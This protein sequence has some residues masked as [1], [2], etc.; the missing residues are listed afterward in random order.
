M[1]RRRPVRDAA[2]EVEMLA[3]EAR[4]LLAK[5]TTEGLDLNLKFPAN[6]PLAQ[7][8]EGIKVHIELAGD[9]S[10]ENEA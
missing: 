1:A 2:T 10:P 7:F 6:G 5:L 8:A 4:E 3:I 9:S